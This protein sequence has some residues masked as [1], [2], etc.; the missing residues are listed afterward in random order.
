MHGIVVDHEIPDEGMSH[1][2]WQCCIIYVRTLIVAFL[3]VIAFITGCVV[4]VYAWVVKL[5][6]VLCRY[7]MMYILFEEGSCQ[8]YK[9]SDCSGIHF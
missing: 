9:A 6:K 1:V 7:L 8:G 2:L 3:I 5:P 4:T